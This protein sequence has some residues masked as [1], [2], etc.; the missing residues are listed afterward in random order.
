MQS[1]KF[2]D[3]A[4]M[5]RFDA[6]IWVAGFMAILAFTVIPGYIFSVISGAIATWL[7]LD[8]LSLYYTGGYGQDAELAPAILSLFYSWV[9]SPIMFAV[10]I[11][12]VQ[13][14]LRQRPIKG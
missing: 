11:W 1:G 5:G 14:Q 8:W 13:T 12:F 7:N 3:D 4:N 10:G 6:A 9:F 2:Y